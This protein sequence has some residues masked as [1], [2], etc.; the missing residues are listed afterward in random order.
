MVDNIDLKV[1]NDFF[2]NYRTE[3]MPAVVL[4]L[5]LDGRDFT[6]ESGEARTGITELRHL[7]RYDP[8]IAERVNGFTA[9]QP[10]P[11]VM[12]TQSHEYIA[13]EPMKGENLGVFRISD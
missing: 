5:V 6:S 11:F 3:P 9:G 10:I 4:E 7:R 8:T 12:D 1:V 2:D 13:Y